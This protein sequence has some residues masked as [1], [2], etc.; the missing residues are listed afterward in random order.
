MSDSISFGMGLSRANPHM[1]THR[2]SGKLVAHSVEETGR[3]CMSEHAEMSGAPTTPPIAR[4][5]A[6]ER[7]RAHRER[8][9]AGLC[10]LMIALRTSFD[11]LVATAPQR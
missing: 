7:M 4:S 5:A 1:Y 11:P 10:C 6:A 9:K 8:R 2:E 3:V